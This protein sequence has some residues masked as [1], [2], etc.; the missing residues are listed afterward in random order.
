M[1]FFIYKGFEQNPEIEKKIFSNM[2]GLEQ[3][4]N[5]E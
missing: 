3:S 2:G 1:T 4:R 5:T